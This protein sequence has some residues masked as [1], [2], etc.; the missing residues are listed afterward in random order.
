MKNIT[1]PACSSITS[2]QERLYSIIDGLEVEVTVSAN[3]YGLELDQLFGMAARINK[4]RG[5]LFVSKVLGKHIP[6]IPALSLGAG[7]MLGCLYEE[8]VL[9][10]PSAL[11][12]ERLRGMFAGRREAEEGYR[13]LMADKIRIDEPT[14]FIGFAETATALGHSMF[15][16]FTGSVSFVHTTREEIEGLVPPIRFEEEHSHAVAHRCYVRDSSVFRNAARVVL[17]DDEM[18]T[19]KT[20]LNIIR[21]LHEAYGHRDFAVASLLDWRSDADRDRYAELERELDIRIRCLALIEGS[22]KVNGNPLE[23][24]ARGQGAPEPQED[25]H[26]LRHDLSEMFEHAGQSSEEAGRSPQLHSYLLH[27]GRFGISVADG[28]ALDRA[29]VEAA[30]LL[31]AHRTGSRALCLGTGEFMYVPMRI[32]ERMGD[33]VYAQSTTRSPIH[34]LRRDGYAVTSAYRY[35]SPDGEEVANFIY[36]VEPGQYDEAFVFVERQYDPARGASFERALSLLG[37]PVVHL[38]TFGASD[39]R[40][41][42]E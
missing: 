33:G 40:R 17:V 24:A 6:V 14:L 29:V 27:T 36:N 31:A 22:I 16:A 23:E 30:G 15:D 8:E 39:D 41:D 2:R 37:V 5:F 21:E 38:V 19:G 26:L 7:A 20:S 3:P 25:F 35:D 28:E 12:A 11:A 34:P 13:K 1:S 18:T 42:G 10:R 32:A 9:K 4:K